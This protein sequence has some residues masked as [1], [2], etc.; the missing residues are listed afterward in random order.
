MIRLDASEPALASLI[1]TALAEDIGPGDIT[2]AA[3]IAPSAALQAVMSARE[4][5]VVAGLPVAAAVFARLAPTAQ[6]TRLVPEAAHVPAGTQLMRLA[7]PARGLLTAERTALNFVQHLS[8]IATLTRSYVAAMAGTGATLL[9]TRK[10]IPGLRT[11]AKYAAACGGAK[12]HRMG[13]FD[14]VMI[15]D[16][17][18]AAAG[19]IARAVAAVRDAGHTK[20]QVECDTLA[21]VEEALRA[22][23]TS[24]L[25]DNMSLEML[26]A[27]VGMVHRQIPTEAS[28]GVRLET[29]RA[30]ALTGVTTISV[31]RLTQ[32][33]AAID[34]GLDTFG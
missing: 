28:G 6:I 34:I 26:H 25:L 12:N 17:H 4:P 1:E 21:Q 18:I 16:N 27:A 9:D 19:S 10:T 13:L 7:G 29:V 2:A 31:G 5:M 24:L 23:A 8:G 20:I 15:K 22:G 14:A 11:L 32:S 30:I 33:A 3:C